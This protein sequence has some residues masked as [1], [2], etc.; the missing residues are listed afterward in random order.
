MSDGAGMT[1]G[2]GEVEV[3]EREPKQDFSEMPAQSR[4]RIVCAEWS[5][6]MDLVAEVTVKNQLSVRGLGGEA[7]FQLEVEEVG[8]AEPADGDG[9][10]DSDEDAYG[11]GAEDAQARP[12]VTCLA[13]RGDGRV[14]VLGLRT[15]AV[16]A[17]SLDHAGARVF[18]TQALPGPVG[19]LAWGGLP[20]PAPGA[21]GIGA[22][23]VPLTG[24]LAGTAAPMR[25]C[26]PTRRSPPP[27]LSLPCSRRCPFPRPS[28]RLCSGWSAPALSSH[29]PLLSVPPPWRGRRRRRGR[30]RASFPCCSART[31]APSARA[32]WR[33]AS[34]ILACWALPGAGA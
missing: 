14:L 19:A 7:L 3:E 4:D 10:I 26:C 9:D 8:E 22:A 20:A 13:W 12:L 15:G 31:L 5:P 1:D 17:H 24:S 30:C 2:G 28:P 16:A 27:P 21:G 25:R 32:C 23:S 29:A 18:W 6:N 34:W 33:A 11:A